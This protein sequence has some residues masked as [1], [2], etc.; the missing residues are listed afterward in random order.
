MKVQLHVHALQCHDIVIT[1]SCQ[2][3]HLRRFLG[4]QKKSLISKLIDKMKC[5]V[6]IHKLNYGVHDIVQIECHNMHAYDI[7]TLTN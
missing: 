6:L 3:W 1:M 2:W 5:V 4:N 7:V